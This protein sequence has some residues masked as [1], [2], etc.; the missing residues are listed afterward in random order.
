MLR[1][2]LIILFTGTFSWSQNAFCL[3]PGDFIEEGERIPSPGRDFGLDTLCTGFQMAVLDSTQDVIIT[4]VEAVGSANNIIEYKALVDGS[5]YNLEN[6][7]TVFES[8]S[9]SPNQTFNLGKHR[10]GTILMIRSVSNSGTVQ[11]YTGPNIE[12]PFLTNRVTMQW[13]RQTFLGGIVTP[14]EGRPKSNEYA[15]QLL[16]AHEDQGGSDF[17]D[18]VMVISNVGV[19]KKCEDASKPGCFNQLPPPY[20]NIP[21]GRYDCIPSKIELEIQAFKNGE[22][23]KTGKKNSNEKIYYTLNGSETREYDPAQGI[24]LDQGVTKNELK[25]WADAPH[26]SSVTQSQVVSFVY[27]IFGALPPPIATPGT[28]N[29]FHEFKSTLDINLSIPSNDPARIKYVFVNDTST[30][31]PD[32]DTWNIISDG[33]SISINESGYLFTFAEDTRPED[34]GLKPSVEAIYEYI[35][36]KE[37]TRAYFHDS[38]KNGQADQIIIEVDHDGKIPTKLTVT[39]DNPMELTNMTSQGGNIVASIDPQILIASNANNE[40]SLTGKYYSSDKFEIEN[41]I[42]RKPTA[43]P[44]SGTKFVGSTEI[45][46]NNPNG[47]GSEIFYSITGPDEPETKPNTLYQ[48]PIELTDS[49]VIRAIA[50]DGTDTSSVAIFEYAIQYQADSAHYVDSNGDGM[51]ETVKIFFSKLNG[52]PDTVQIQNASSTRQE[53]D[54]T[55]GSNNLELMVNLNQPIPHELKT[56]SA[57]SS[58]KQSILMRK[59]HWKKMVW[60]T[61]P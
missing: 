61:T 9:V 50:V 10:R 42:L 14:T 29:G 25:A 6:F 33:S 46:L 55:Q 5:D 20:P 19:V 44:P 26:D 12:D 48:T 57:Q 58:Q 31:I 37:V 8:K 7:Q 32:K 49:K 2:M 59:F 34:E 1:L 27:E 17:N 24:Q 30:G 54:I 35:R 38:D 39:G 40:G 43:D 52:I 47:D 56:S 45:T 21:P 36:L 4:F 51:V 16:L 28:R 53:T 60:T 15:G 18:V 11:R 3:G 41:S 13:G 23:V 22:L